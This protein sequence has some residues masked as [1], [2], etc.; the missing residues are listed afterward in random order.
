[1][2]LIDAA[3]WSEDDTLHLATALRQ[4]HF[5]V[6]LIVASGP[7]T[8]RLIDSPEIYWIEA[9]SIAAEH[10][11]LEILDPH[12]DRE[13]RIPYTRSYFAALALRLARAIRGQLPGLPALKVIAVDCDNT[14]WRGICGE[15]GPEGVALDPGRRRLQEFL[16]EQRA[17]GK[18]ICLT[19]KNNEEDVWETFRAHPEFP[20]RPADCVS[21][22]INWEP[23][24]HN[25]ASLSEELSLGA[26]SFVLIDD[27]RRECGEV[28]SDFPEALV[29]ELPP[30]SDTIGAWLDNLWVFDQQGKVTEEDLKRNQ[31]YSEI[32]ARSRLERQTASFEEFIARLELKIEIEPL[33]PASMTRSAQLTQR[34]NQMNL[35]TVRRSE[36][37]LRQ[38]IE[39]GT[40]EGR[41]VHVRDRF[42]DYGLV[43]LLLLRSG[44]SDDLVI[45]TMLLSCRA[46][47]RGVEHAMLREAAA[48]AQSRGLE[49][50]EIEYK[51][52]RKNTPARSLVESLEGA[53]PV[54]GGYRIASVGLAECEFKPRR[55][56]PAPA[57]EQ[58][59]LE[60]GK[61]PAVHGDYASIAALKGDPELLLAAL[62]P[63]GSPGSALASGTATEE[64]LA[65]IW[66]G[67]LPVSR[68]ELDDDFF[69]LGGHS[70]LAV[71]L[72][73]RIRETFGV[74][75]SLDLIYSEKLTIRRLAAIIDNNG[76]IPDSTGESTHLSEEEYA[77]LLAE[78]ENL[79][80]E[81]VQ[82]LLLRDGQ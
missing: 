65:G 7:G 35:S 24:S 19:S 28:R 56:A 34:T 41:V 16:V 22:R 59:Q 45:D 69:D 38:L 32:S 78:V 1:M 71:Q 75:L 67:L 6:P 17:S 60:I 10:P 48:I 74:E 82:T 25:L 73:T 3:N 68:F 23:K 18:L 42:G 80:D 37:E 2:V 8:P 66:A 13:A 72:L 26:D 39:A 77:A 76:A 31:Y 63:P 57:G 5:R 50:V 4:S 33:A 49:F 53:Q 51:P 54:E 44:D 9:D 61:Q 47:G 81:E 30:N 43:G 46:M 52:T 27:D 29:L 70:L 64:C 21:W 79:S 55:P 14:L 36:A 58:P 40:V 62:H 20:L 11:T 15:D 12:A